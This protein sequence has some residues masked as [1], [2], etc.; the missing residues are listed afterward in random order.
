M[1]LTPQLKVPVLAARKDTITGVS[2][3]VDGASPVNLDVIEDM[4]LAAEQIFNGKFG[5]T[6]LKTSVR[7]MIKYTAAFAA[8]KATAS[9]SNDI[10]G[11]GTLAAAQ[12]AAE[13]SEVPDVRGARYIPGKAYV[14]GITLDPGKH[15][16]VITF[17]DGTKKEFKDYEVKAGGLNLLEAVNLK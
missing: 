10:A 7:T 4:S 1:M 14:G 5:A 11:V 15:N 17:S 3:S 6:L 12:K 16:I 9:Q 2:V 8:A 13:A